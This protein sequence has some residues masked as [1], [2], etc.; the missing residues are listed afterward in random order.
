MPAPRLRPM[1]WSR[2]APGRTPRRRRGTG[3]PVRAAAG[4]APSLPRTRSWASRRCRARR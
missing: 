3:A 4:T 2:R 1:R